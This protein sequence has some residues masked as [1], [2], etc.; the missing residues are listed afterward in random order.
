MTTTPAVERY[1]DN[2]NN[3]STPLSHYRERGLEAFQK[4]GIPHTK[5]EE[6]RYTSL[7]SF[8]PDDLCLPSLPEEKIT[9][10][11]WG[12]GLVFLNGHHQPKEDRLPQGVT[13]QTNRPR[14]WWEASSPDSFEALNMATLQSVVTLEIAPQSNPVEPLCL[15]HTITAS[16]AGRFVSP[17]VEIIVGAGADVT[18]LEVFSS[19]EKVYQHNAMTKIQLDE[20]AR[21]EH[22][23]VVQESLE[24]LHVGTVRARLAS[25][26][27]LSSNTFSLSGGLVRNNI[28]I[29]LDGE[30]SFV[31]IMG[32]Y[33]INGKQHHDNFTRVYHNKKN[34]HSRQIFKGI[35]DDRARGV[36]TGKIVVGRGCPGVDSRLLNKNLLLA[37][38]AHADTRPQLEVYTDDVQCSHGATTGQIS[39]EELFYLESRGIDKQAA[40]KILHYAFSEEIV[41]K[42]SNPQ[43]RKMVAQ[44]MEQKQ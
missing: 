7:S 24:A 21:L 13:L 25:S 35:L 36:F 18:L 19:A 3:F 30:E 26:A 11:P 39:P 12:E 10:S 4:R 41:A 23:K 40:K 14:L 2:I 38:K 20:G 31:N 15:S 44:A 34:T 17:H 32:L 9:Q 5:Q 42:T 22:I 29:E 37:P 28:D 16:G 6:W 1:I 8:L 33:A 43:I 27:H